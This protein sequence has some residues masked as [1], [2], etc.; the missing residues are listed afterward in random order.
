MS[1]FTLLKQAPRVALRI[2]TAVKTCR[3]ILQGILRYVSESGQWAIRIIEERGTD[4]T[5]ILGLE[6]DGYSGFIGNVFNARNRQR[7]VRGGMPCIL[8]DTPP[9]TGVIQCDNAP[10]GHAAADHFLHQG[11]TRFAFVGDCGCSDWSNAR[12]RAFACRLRA[13]GFP[14]SS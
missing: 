5:T 9:G 8:I 13:H 7:L 1:H 12:G 10:I 2:S 3:E 14:C 4:D 6:R 11:F